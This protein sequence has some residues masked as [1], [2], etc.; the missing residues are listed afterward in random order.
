MNPYSATSYCVTLDKSSHPLKL[1]KK[2]P[3]ILDI[4]SGQS[5][6]HLC[7]Q[8]ACHNVQHIFNTQQIFRHMSL[9]QVQQNFLLIFNAKKFYLTSEL[10]PCL[11]LPEQEN[12]S[13]K[14]KGK[15]RSPENDFPPR[16]SWHQTTFALNIKYVFY[17]KY[18]NL[19]Q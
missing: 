1:S 7:A 15:P 18:K 10:I 13:L 16:R 19:T 6:M 12:L 11:N 5:H 14:Q 2:E 9:I 17:I 8:H 3:P 4:Q